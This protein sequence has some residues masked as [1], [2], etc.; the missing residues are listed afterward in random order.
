MRERNA[1]VMASD[2]NY[3]FATANVIIGVEKHSRGLIDKYIIYTPTDNPVSKEDQNAAFRLC[4]KIEFRDYRQPEIEDKFIEKYK[5][6]YSN[7]IFAKF[8]IFDILNE[9]ENVLWLDSDLLIQKD[10]SYI[11]TCKPMAWRDAVARVI[12]RLSLKGELIQKPDFASIPADATTPNGGVI[13][14]SKTNEMS[15]FSARECYETLAE[16]NRTIDYIGASDEWIFGYLAWKHQIPV[17][18][19]SKEFNNNIC[20]PNRGG[21]EPSIV[22]FYEPGPLRRKVWKDALYKGVYSEWSD[23]VEKWLLAGGSAYDGEVG[24]KYLGET[25]VQIC[26]SMNRIIYWSNLLKNKFFHEH[27]EIG[28]LNKSFIQFFLP[29]IDH[30]VHYE[31]LKKDNKILVCLHF[32]NDKFITHKMVDMVTN[33]CSRWGVLNAS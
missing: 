24:R 29:Q 27:I 15:E 14:V 7:L 8:K 23:N 16:I 12:N 17:V 1:I 18:H 2:S 6:R 33:A 11:F 20:D 4:D 5:D 26:L 32:E 31:L 3:M 30:R 9:Y 19:L 21:K 28:D 22:H 25:S 13:F 10:I